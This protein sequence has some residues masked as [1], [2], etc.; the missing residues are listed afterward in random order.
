MNNKEQNKAILM[1]NITDRAEEIYDEITQFAE[2]R[3]IT[4]EQAAKCFELAV[5]SVTIGALDYIG[6]EI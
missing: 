5:G 6:R 3:D 2:V 4:F 1:K